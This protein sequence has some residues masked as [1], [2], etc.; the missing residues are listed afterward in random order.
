MSL[1]LHSIAPCEPF[2]THELANT[3]SFVSIKTQANGIDKT[4]A[5][6]YIC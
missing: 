6:N 1:Q 2:S 4:E 5:K 3:R